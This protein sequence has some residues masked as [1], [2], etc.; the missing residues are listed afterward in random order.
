MDT[1][2]DISRTRF[3][4]RRSDSASSQSRS[5]NLDSYRKNGLIIDETG[6]SLTISAVQAGRWSWGWS[7]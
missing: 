5:G 1:L 6:Y 4:D 7:F 2:V 3:D